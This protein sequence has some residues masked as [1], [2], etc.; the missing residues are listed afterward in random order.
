M[1]LTNLPL[2]VLHTICECLDSHLDVTSFRLV[3]R[4]FGDIGLKFLTPLV[5]V[6]PTAES[7]ARLRAISLHPVL[8]HHVSGVTFLINVFYPDANYDHWLNRVPRN[9]N[10]RD[11]G[12]LYY[13]WYRAWR[14][15]KNLLSG[16]R[17]AFRAL[18]PAQGVEQACR[19]LTNLDHLEIA[20][21]F[22]E[23]DYLQQNQTYKSLLQW[24]PRYNVL[25][26]QPFYPFSAASSY[27]GPPDV[28][29]LKAFLRAMT[30][31][32]VR[33]LRV[34]VLDVG[35]FGGY[36]TRGESHMREGLSHLRALELRL[37]VN[38]DKWWESIPVANRILSTNRLRDFLCL[39]THLEKLRVTFKWYAWKN[40]YSHVKIANVLPRH[41]WPHLRSLQIDSIEI[42]ASHFLD[43]I[44]SHQSTL[45][46]MSLRDCLLANDP[47]Q[48]LEA[49]RSRWPDV[50]VPLV[51]DPLDVLSL[52]GSFKISQA[53]G[54]LQDFEIT[55]GQALAI[56]ICS[57]E[58]DSFL[59]GELA[60]RGDLKAE[61]VKKALVEDLT[62]ELQ[63]Q[64]GWGRS[65]IH[66]KRYSSYLK[67]FAT[68]RENAP[69]W[70]AWWRRPGDC[71]ILPEF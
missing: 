19:S 46:L 2:D 34:K 52:R 10:L 47:D 30:G 55:V 71:T 58:F 49:P 7:I 21:S 42:V 68:L 18:G 65:K 14:I 26:D 33:N 17:N 36:E 62:G 56:V 28:K 70:G 4:A 15:Y 69:G 9:R 12:G 27:T 57:R 48:G 16:Q 22:Y 51:F 38:D 41:T 63:K 67:S 43:F 1:A 39:A 31:S 35:F 3:C 50:F 13:H 32:K 53:H 64:K 5:T 29:P 37:C 8:R 45:K 25:E 11:L 60:G 24:L 20:E 66:I 59:Q 6:V 44:S 61:A 54:L 23:E 40:G